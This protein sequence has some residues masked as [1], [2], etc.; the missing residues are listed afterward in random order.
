MAA[1]GSWSVAL[2]ATDGQQRSQILLRV[3]EALKQLHAA[4]FVHGD[5][6]A[7]NVLYK[8]EPDNTVKV[9]LIDFDESGRVG[10]AYYGPL[11]FNAAIQRAPGVAPGMAIDPQHDLWPTESAERFF[12]CGYH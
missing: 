3:K 12:V 8:V 6:R 4:G 11:P 10:L 5:V 1:D 7:S 9:M 2:N